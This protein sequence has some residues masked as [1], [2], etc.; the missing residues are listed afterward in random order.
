[1]FR[2]K[3]ERYWVG[4]YPTT[5]D[6]Q[7]LHWTYFKV[8]YWRDISLP[9]RTSRQL[10]QSWILDAEKDKDKRCWV[11]WRAPWHRRCLM[12]ELKQEH[13]KQLSSDS[14]IMTS[15]CATLEQEHPRITECPWKQSHI[16]LYVTK[17]STLKTRSFSQKTNVVYTKI[18]TF[19]YL[20]SLTLIPSPCLMW[21]NY[22]NAPKH[23][24]P[25][26]P[27]LLLQPAFH[28]HSIHTFLF[29]F[30]TWN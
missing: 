7:W 27:C 17:I 12:A 4:W 30:I 20:K 22:I 25:M 6:A 21:T 28:F 13:E 3:R 29:I 9:R 8:R 24:Y 11:K 5:G 26:F 18:L 15:S 2:D 16:N 10:G 14:F 1:M 23:C 19:F